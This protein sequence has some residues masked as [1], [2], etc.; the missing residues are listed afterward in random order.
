MLA[1]PICQL[2][3]NCNF[4]VTFR[5]KCALCRFQNCILL[6]GE[7]QSHWAAEALEKANYEKDHQEGNSGADRIAGG[8]KNMKIQAKDSIPTDNVTREDLIGA[9]GANMAPRVHVSQLPLPASPRQAAGK[10]SSCSVSVAGGATGGSGNV[11]GGA[12]GRIGSVAGGASGGSSSIAGGATPSVATSRS[13][14]VAGEA[15]GGSGCVVG[16]ATTH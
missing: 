6:L 16:G 13:G 10:G 4:H 15:T 5:K 9:L 1:P 14:R 8:L 7:Q 12:T 11:A 2:G 3:G